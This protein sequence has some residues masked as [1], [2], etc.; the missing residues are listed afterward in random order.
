LYAYSTPIERQMAVST[1]AERASGYG[2]PVVR[3]DGN[4]VEAVH[5]AA[6]QAIE[7]ARA[8][9]GP[10]FIEGFTYR[11]T[12]HSA[13]DDTSYVPP[14]MLEEGKARDPLDAF[15]RRLQERG[16]LDGNE[17]VQLQESVKDAVETG[18]KRALE[19]PYPESAD[20]AGGVYAD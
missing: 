13:A 6:S 15:V 19:S 5:E 4:D 10:S 11:M 14:E 1:V 17:L 2:M 16:M 3:V 8:G 18:L 9:D 12:G 7:R 20:A